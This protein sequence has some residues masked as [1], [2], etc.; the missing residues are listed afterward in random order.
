MYVHLWNWENWE[1]LAEQERFSPKIADGLP[2]MCFGTLASTGEL[3]CL[4]RGKLGYYPTVWSTDDPERNEEI[5]DYN[6]TR[7][8]VTA[9]QRQAMEIG[10]MQ[11]WGVPGADPATYET[12]SQEDQTEDEGMVMGGM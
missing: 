10:S 2:E 9:A 11:G 4:K 8:G 6:N 12:I 3:I 5:A 7:L 1:L